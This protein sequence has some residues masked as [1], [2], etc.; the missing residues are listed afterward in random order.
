[1]PTPVRS[2]NTGIVPPYVHDSIAATN[3]KSAL[4][5]LNKK[6]R[7]GTRTLAFK[8]GTRAVQ[9]DEAVKAL[10][11]GKKVKATV[12]AFKNIRGSKMT[13]GSYF[14]AKVRVP[15]IKIETLDSVKEL[16]AFAKAN[17]FDPNKAVVRGG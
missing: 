9:T 12:V 14:R 6:G 1:M 10:Q 17:V 3:V 15:G 4:V 13:G 5:D 7:V 2:G 11:S 16:Q 8:V